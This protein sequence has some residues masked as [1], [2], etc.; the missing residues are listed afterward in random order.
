MV[1]INIVNGYVEYMWKFEVNWGNL[2][3]LLSEIKKN[4]YEE[5]GK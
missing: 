2:I 3:V 5:G 4:L 1:S